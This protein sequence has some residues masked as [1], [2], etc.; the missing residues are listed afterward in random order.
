MNRLFTLLV[1]F[2]SCNYAP[3][4]K[5]L[6][7]TLSSTKTVNVELIDSLGTITLSIPKKYDTSFSWVQYSDCG[8]PCDKQKYRFQP[9]YLPIVKESGWMWAD[10]PSDS[11]DQFTISHSKYFPFHDGDTAKNL[12]RY[13]NFKEVL[14][15]KSPGFSIVFDTIEKINDRYYSIIAMEKSDSLILKK[16][17]ALTTI[18]GNEI[19]FDYYL[20]SKR[21][22]PSATNFIRNSI[23]L[24]RTIRI[25]KGT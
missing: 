9:K 2:I 17:S 7:E 1:L 11:I 4:D 12:I 16:V 18:K 20:S 6:P 24:V 15:T 14:L 23:E 22:S 10:N 21:N 13:N 5:R 19:K 8:K 25:S 3:P